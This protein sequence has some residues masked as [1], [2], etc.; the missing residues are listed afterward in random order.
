MK[1]CV[2]FHDHRSRFLVIEDSPTDEQSWFPCSTLSTGGN[3]TVHHPPTPSISLSIKTP[4]NHQFVYS[5]VVSEARGRY[6]ILFLQ[7]FKNTYILA[8]IVVVMG[9][10]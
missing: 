4:S 9:R 2:I 1:V 8:R 10:R 3:F 6:F 5:F 7:W